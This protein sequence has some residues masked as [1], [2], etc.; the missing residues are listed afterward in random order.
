MILRALQSAQNC[1]VIECARAI[2][3][4]DDGDQHQD[5]TGKGVQEEFNGRVYT[6][7]VSPD[8][9]QEVE[10]RA[11]STTSREHVEQEEI[12]RGEHADETEFQQQEEGEKLFGAVLDV[13]PRDQDRD[14]SQERRQNDQPEAQTVDADMPVDLGIGDPNRVTDEL[15]A[16]LSR[17]ISRSQPQGEH[18]REQRDAES[19]HADQLILRPGDQK[20]Q[21]ETDAGDGDQEIEK[22]HRASLTDQLPP[23]SR[24]R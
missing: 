1:R 6:P 19:H 17:L 8:A 5:R 15:L 21:D 11:T 23:Q 18:K 9:D 3:N 4:E 7:I 22:I 2:V 14:G 10:H 13:T 24:V 16:G 12:P 20:S